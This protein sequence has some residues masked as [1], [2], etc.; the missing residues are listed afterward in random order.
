MDKKNNLI[1]II[2]HYYK[3][4]EEKVM[5][6]GNIIS[7]QQKLIK[8]PVE[9]EEQILFETFDDSSI[10]RI[11]WAKKEEVEFLEAKKEMWTKEEIEQRNKE[12]NGE[13]I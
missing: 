2:I 7:A 11:F 1:E 10:K 8:T 4:K 3:L 5:N 6:D 13:W 12:I 9:D